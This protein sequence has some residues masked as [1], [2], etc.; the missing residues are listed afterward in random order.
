[1]HLGRVAALTL[2]TRIKRPVVAALLLGAASLGSAAPADLGAFLG[3]WRGTS[4]C[5]NR[6][7]A[8]ACKDEIIVYDVR[9]SEKP[10]T[11]T[12]KADKI[13]DGKRV[14][15]GEL[16]FAYDP[17]DACWRSELSTPRVHG[18]WCLSIQGQAMTGSL[19]VLPDNQDVRK[20]QL[21]R[22]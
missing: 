9:R 8:P 6:E 12:V 20:V 15:M 3:T 17:K 21:K 18:V 1:M 10:D 4:T 16:D 22:E 2:V 13:V 5:V 14:P 11:A 7:I 19:R